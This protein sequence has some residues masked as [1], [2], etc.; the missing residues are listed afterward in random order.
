MTESKDETHRPGVTTAQGD[1]GLPDDRAGESIG[2]LLS[3]VGIYAARQFAE[4]LSGLD[5]QPP[6]FRVMNVVDAAE[7][8]SQQAIA[9][10]IGAPASRMVMI[11][12][13]LEQR[14]LIERRT[15]PSDRRAHAL[16]LTTNGRKL[17]ARARKIAHQHEDEIM[18]G[19]GAA[20]RKR[21]IALLQQVVSQQE[22]GAGVHPGLREPESKR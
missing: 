17:L 22:I 4:R 3:Q 14:G 18:R 12:D 5:L 9:E 20:D 19:I 11:V 7:G 1:G 6:Q 21:L 8:L 2:F 16:F 10:A 15:D 13:E